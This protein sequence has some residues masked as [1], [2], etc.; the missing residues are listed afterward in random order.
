VRS[1]ARWKK[2]FE[3]GDVS[4]WSNRPFSEAA[5]SAEPK[6]TCE[7]YVEPLSDARTK[8]AAFFN[9]LGERI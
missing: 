3:R 2:D 4:G 5:A 9:I 7:L 8:L 1:I 6:R